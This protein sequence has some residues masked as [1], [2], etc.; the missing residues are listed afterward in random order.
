MGMLRMRFSNPNGNAAAGND[1]DLDQDSAKN[2]PP[3]MGNMCA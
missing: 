1:L 3:L 2:F